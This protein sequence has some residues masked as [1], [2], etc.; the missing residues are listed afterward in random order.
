M[1]KEPQKIAKEGHVKK[2]WHRPTVRDLS[3]R[4]TDSRVDLFWPTEQ[5]SGGGNRIG[6]S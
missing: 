1:V 3:A 2:P 5:T 4:Q 6:P